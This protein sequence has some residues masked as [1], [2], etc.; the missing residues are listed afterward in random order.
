MQSI[1]ENIKIQDITK[2]EI[3]KMIK[4]A[5]KRDVYVA[6]EFLNLCY[7]KRKDMRKKLIDIQYL[8]IDKK[9]S[10]K[11]EKYINILLYK[12]KAEQEKKEV[13]KY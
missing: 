11:A 3:L 8:L 7:K 13:K 4:I 10:Q 12:M 5:I 2:E 6:K 1:E 9:D